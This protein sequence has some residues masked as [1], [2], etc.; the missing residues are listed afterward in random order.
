MDSDK[1]QY[2]DLRIQLNVNVPEHRQ[3]Y[4]ILSSYPV[5]MR[6]KI[7]TD[8]MLQH[9]NLSDIHA[10]EE[11]VSDICSDKLNL[12]LKVLMDKIDDMNSVADMIAKLNDR[13]QKLESRIDIQE[14]GSIKEEKKEKGGTVSARENSENVEPDE[15][16]IP[17][18]E[19]ILGFLGGL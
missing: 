9:Y 11:S 2:K 7:I 12:K 3:L 6:N 13:V 1:Y 18:P 19:E 8:I 4:D 10:S 14:A 15:P 16:D 17:I 5:R